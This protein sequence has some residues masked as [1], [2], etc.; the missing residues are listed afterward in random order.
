MDE[1]GCYKN[2]K[3]SIGPGSN[4]VKM[5]AKEAETRPK[6]FWR[7]VKSQTG[8]RERLSSLVK[9]EAL[10]TQNEEEKDELL[11]NVLVQFSSER[12]NIH[13]QSWKIGILATT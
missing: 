12:M 2:Y 5:I 10:P 8:T 11:N 3:T 9:Q 4:F 13:F 6:A 1:W 7:Y